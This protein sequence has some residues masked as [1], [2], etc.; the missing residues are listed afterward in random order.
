MS[1]FDNFNYEREVLR[2]QRTPEGRAFMGYF[3]ALKAALRSRDPAVLA[4]LAEANAALARTK[5]LGPNEV[6]VDATLSDVSIRYAN[7]EYIGERLC[8]IASVP[9]R[10]N[11]FFAYDE[12][13][14]LGFPDDKL[15]PRGQANEVS[16]SLNKKNYS[17]EDYG[18]EG[19][20][21]LTTIANADAPLDPLT[22][23][24]LI[25]NEGLA[26]N[27]ELRIQRLMCDPNNYG[28]NVN[29][30]TPGSE[31]N[32]AG[33][34]KPVEQIQKGVD[35]IYGGMG[36]SKLIGFCNVNVFRVLS[37]HPAIRELFKFEKDGFAT[38][39]QIAQYFELDELL[40]GR[41]RKDIANKG[42]K[43]NVQRIWP[44]VFG[45]VRVTDMPSIKC[46]TFGITFRNGPVETIELFKR[47][48]GKKGS[49]LIKATVTE[50][51]RVVAPMAGYLIQNCFDVAQA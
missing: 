11:I 25:V 50:D 10:S 12:R 3:R 18:L 44:D 42:Q 32:S 38:R 31:W 48:L 30:L 49:Y 28:G 9:F 26:F 45:I 22:D 43:A 33:G 7:D 40:V 23:E 39:N 21:D 1:P 46:Y 24:A 8:P 51:H 34:G 16:Q 29:A 15:G 5:E 47:D 19:F 37:R 20:V 36:P 4:D 27:R 6:H 2:G 13:D 41:A 35:A 14:Q 17:T